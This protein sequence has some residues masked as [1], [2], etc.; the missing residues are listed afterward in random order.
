MSEAVETKPKRARAPKKKAV[1]DQSLIMNVGG[2]PAAVCPVTEQV[3][4]RGIA[5]VHHPVLCATLPQVL[6]HLKDSGVSEAEYQEKR[7]LIAA[8]FA[9]PLDVAIPMKQPTDFWAA[10]TKEHGFSVAEWQAK[11]AAHNAPAPKPS[12]AKKAKAAK[13][14]LEAG[15]YAVPVGKAGRGK[16]RAPQ[17]LDGPVEIARAFAKI[18]SEEPSLRRHVVDA[19]H[20]HI[21]GLVEKEGSAGQAPKDQFNPFVTQLLPA[22][23]MCGK[24]LMFVDKKVSMP[25]AELQLEEGEI[26]FDAE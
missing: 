11:L 23:S 12:K 1:K 4:K 8:E 5:S 17:R 20:L 9:Q 6:Q 21:V 10:H 22:V 26:D 13:V 24:V 14:E 16:A 19:E 7:A 3:I 25:V 18:T 15:V 2:E